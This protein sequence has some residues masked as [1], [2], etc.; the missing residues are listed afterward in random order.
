[1]LV[2]FQDGEHGAEVIR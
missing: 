2:Y 1:M